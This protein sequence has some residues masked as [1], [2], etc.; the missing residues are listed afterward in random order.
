MNAVLKQASMEVRL[1][2]AHIRLI[3]HPETCLYGGVILM[4]ETSVVDDPAA[5]PTAY[6]DGYNKR[7]GRAFLERLTDAEVAGLVLHENLHVMMKHIPRHRDLM[8]ENGR[9]ANMAMDYAVNDIIQDLH[10][11]HPALVKLGDGWLYDP[12]FKGW[13][14]RRIYEYLKQEQEGGGGGGGG[15]R[16]DAL[17]EHDGS[18]HDEM[19]EAQQE[20]AK[21]DVDDAIHQ[22][23]ILAGKFGAKIPRQVKDMMAPPVDWREALREFWGAYARGADELTW[24]RFNKHRV[25][26]DHFLPSLINETVGE[27]VLPIDTSGS[28]SNDDIGRVAACI[29]ELCDIVTPERIRVLWWDTHVHGEQVFE[30]D[31]TNLKNLLKPMGGGGTRV[32]C[33]S[34]Y[35]IERDIKADCMIVFTDGY[36][37][38]N[39]NW[40]TNVP[41]LWLVK[42]NRHFTPPSG[43]VINVED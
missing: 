39:I 18:S 8:K 2:K 12:M 9:L 10:L 35:I 14:V 1:K 31:Y 34:E 17:D 36:V 4:G 30:G 21:R 7:Y 19:T 15:G 11:S 37:E 23:G 27:V 43:S 24:R 22:G 40:K 33:V 6:T 25:A 38:G 13:S 26:D 29:Q 42:G 3:K 41:T 16:G 5:C 28:I 32:G 20:Q